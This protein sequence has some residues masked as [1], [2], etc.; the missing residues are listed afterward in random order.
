VCVPG[1]PNKRPRS[2]V[3]PTDPN[4]RAKPVGG[5]VPG[6]HEIDAAWGDTDDPRILKDR[7]RRYKAQVAKV[8]QDRADMKVAMRLKTEE[9]YNEGL[10]SVAPQLLAIDKRVAEITTALLE[11]HLG[12]DELK[13]LKTLLPELSKQRDRLYGKTRQRVDTTSLS[14]SV[15]INE[16]QRQ[17]REALPVGDAERAEPI[18]VEVLDEEMID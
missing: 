3:P 4:G 17:S 8:K 12:E 10:L 6:S 1:Q 7:L 15:D 13:L 5:G 18:D 16:L 11:G 14:A 9:A 2:E